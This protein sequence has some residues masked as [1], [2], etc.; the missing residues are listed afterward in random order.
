M[1]RRTKPNRKSLTIVKAQIHINWRLG[2]WKL[3]G[4][5]LQKALIVRTP[6]CIS[7]SLKKTHSH[8]GVGI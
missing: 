3:K 4:N 2:G 6:I 5:A 7:P 1:R 8:S